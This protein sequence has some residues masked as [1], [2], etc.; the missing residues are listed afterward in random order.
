MLLV[1][2]GWFSSFFWGAASCALL[3]GPAAA[4]DFVEARR[5]ALGRRGWVGGGER[6]EGGVLAKARRVPT[7]IGSPL[8]VAWL[9]Q[10]RSKFHVKF[11]GSCSHCVLLGLLVSSP[12]LDVG[13]AR[14][15]AP[16]TW[17]WCL[18]TSPASPNITGL[19]FWCLA[20]PLAVVAF[21]RR[22]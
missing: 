16:S 11:Y 14:W 22:S 8:L 15:C 9:D 19:Q 20:Q 2:L 17:H 4:L 6:E 3:V 1:L 12:R 10:L 5:V 21:A 13:S 18:Q 7:P